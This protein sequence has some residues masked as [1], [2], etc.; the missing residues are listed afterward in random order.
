MNS[1]LQIWSPTALAILRIVTGFLFLQHGS[2][3]LLGFPYDAK[4]AATPIASLEGVAGLLELPGGCLIMLGLLTRPVAFLLSGEM[5]VAYFIA[6]APQ[7]HVLS[8]FLNHGELAVLY[9]FIFLYLVFAGPGAWSVDARVRSTVGRSVLPE[10]HA[11]GSL[12]HQ[13]K[14]TERE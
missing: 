7:G 11:Q 14:S 8:P 5:A 6:H 3:K 13:S 12:A 4:E 9:C 10:P 2:M 1:S